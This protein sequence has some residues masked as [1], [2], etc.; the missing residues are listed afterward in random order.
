MQQLFY[1]V[2]QSPGMRTRVV[3]VQQSMRKSCRGFHENQTNELR[4]VTFH[5]LRLSSLLQPSR[6]GLGFFIDPHSQSLVLARISKAIPA[7]VQVCVVSSVMKLRISSKSASI[8]FA[9]LAIHPY[10][11]CRGRVNRR[12][13]AADKQISNIAHPDQIVVIT[14]VLVPG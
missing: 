2:R 10:S 12:C 11:S 9:K 3:G 7:F 14:I 13:H 5:R 6:P 4:V 1:P 8:G